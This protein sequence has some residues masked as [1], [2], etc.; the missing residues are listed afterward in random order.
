MHDRLVRCRNRRVV[1]S[2]SDKEHQRNHRKRNH[3][4][5]PEDI[6]ERK[7]GGLSLQFVVE[8]NLGR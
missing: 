7:H 3:A 5:N 4:E 6:D 8:Q 2:S 1:T